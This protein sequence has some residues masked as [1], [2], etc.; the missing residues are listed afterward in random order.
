MMRWM[1]AGPG[2]RARG[3]PCVMRDDQWPHGFWSHGGHHVNRMT[4]TYD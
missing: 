4:D 3:V 1:D 2:V